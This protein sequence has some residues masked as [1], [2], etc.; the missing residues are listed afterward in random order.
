ML[1]EFYGVTVDYLV[2]HSIKELPATETAAL[3]YKYNK[4]S[5]K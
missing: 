4:L 1:A 3:L 5:D 2:G